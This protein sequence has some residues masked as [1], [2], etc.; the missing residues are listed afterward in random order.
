MRIAVISDIHANVI[1]LNAVIKHMEGQRID[2]IIFLGDLVINGPHPKEALEEMRRLSPSVWIKGNTDEWLH[3]VGVGFKPNTEREEYLY[4]LFKY[5][6][7]RLDL[8]EK[9][10]LLSKPDKQLIEIEGVNILCVH[11][12]NRSMNEQIGIMTSTERFEQMIN[13]IEADVLLC[14]HTHLTYVASFDGKKIINSGSISL[15][16][17]GDPRASYGILDIDKDNVSYSNYRVSYDIDRVINDAITN[18]F[19]YIDLYKEKLSKTK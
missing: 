2:K 15:S 17:D 19:P 1:A 12:S 3:E 4:E 10:F 11:G 7:E 14:G 8:E 9:E 5:A 18:R 13:E 16:K 6:N